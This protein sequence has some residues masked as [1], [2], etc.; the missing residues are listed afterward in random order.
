MRTLSLFVLAF[1]FATLFSAQIATAAKVDTVVTQ[2]KVMKKEIKA[3]VVTPAGYSASNKYPV[4]YLL[5]GF[6]DNYS[7]WLKKPTEPN[8]VERLCDRFN[9]IVV[10]PD[11]ATSWFMDSPVDPA[12]RY[13]TY[14]TSELIPY[15]DAHFASVKDRSG[16][17]IT[18]LS[19][20]GHGALYLAF[21]HQDIFGAVGS[22]S[23]G[24]DLRPFPNNW[25]LALD[26]GKYNER[27]ENWDNNSVVNLTHLLTPNSLAIIFDC[28]SDDFFYKVNLNLHNELL[29]RNIPHDFTVR[30][31][32]HTWSYW[33][34]SINYQMLFFSRYFANAKS[35]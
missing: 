26:L 14:I 13:E 8:E 3:V 22:M 10:C 20:G 34:N 1:C 23:G 30:P 4:V 15:I 16:R 19:M 27:H 33:S 35:K 11:G 17:A 29:E 32:G 25:N 5:H 6:S 2:S 31:G 28:G 21:R 9:V 24:V 18:G 12:I 7:A